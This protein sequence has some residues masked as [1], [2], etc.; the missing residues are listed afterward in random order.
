V[1]FVGRLTPQKGI[2]TAIRVAKMSGRKLR[3]AGPVPDPDWFNRA[4]RPHLG[5]DFGD[6]GEVDGREVSNLMATSKSTLFPIRSPEAFGLVMAESLACETPVIALRS[7]PVSEVVRSGVLGFVCE[8]EEEMVAAVRGIDKISRDICRSDAVARFSNGRMVD[9]YL[10]V[11][12]D[13]V[14]VGRWTRM[15]WYADGSILVGWPTAL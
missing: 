7:G 6:L 2:D 4:V 15:E 3:I 13:L 8:S 12:E 9:D 1:A 10:R 11:L 5:S 14:A